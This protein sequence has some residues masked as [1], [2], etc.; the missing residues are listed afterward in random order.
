MGRILIVVGLIVAL[1]AAVFVWS[2]DE[3]ADT[4]DVA[5]QPATVGD[6]RGD[7]G[8]NTG[9]GTILPDN[10][11]PDS[12]D[13]FDPKP[14][15][16]A[17]SSTPVEASEEPAAPTRSISGTVVRVSDGSPLANLHVAIGWID[18]D[19]TESLSTDDAPI[20]VLTLDDPPGTFTLAAVP[21]DADGLTLYSSGPWPSRRATH[22]IEPG[23]GDLTDL[24]LRF[25]SGFSVAGLVTDEN[26]VPIP[27]ALVDA[28][29]LGEITAD[30]TGHFFLRDVAPNEDTESVEIGAR[31]PWFQHG[32]EAVVVPR[33]SSEI[34]SVHV[35]LVGSGALEGQ[36]TDHAGGA[37]A[38][39][40]VTLEY[41]MT[42]NHGST[43][44]GGLDATSDAEGRYRIDHVPPGRYI[45]QSAPP[46]PDTGIDGRAD[47]FIP[48]PT[49]G[50][51][52]VWVPDV[53]V[54]VGEATRLDIALPSGAT[55]SG[56]VTDQYG[57]P[58]V[59]AVV[60]LEKSV[61]WA[62]PD[63]SGSSTT[64]SPDLRIVSS[65]SGD[66]GGETVLTTKE[67]QTTS[68][69]NGDYI[70]GR[71]TPGE[72]L[73]TSS[74]PDGDRVTQRETLFVTR[75]RPH[76]RDIQ[77]MTGVTMR[78]RVVDRAGEPIEG[79]SVQV[80]PSDTAVLDGSNRVTTDHDGR[81]EMTGLAPTEMRLAIFKSGYQGVFE[82]VDPAAPEAEYMMLPAPSVNGRVLDALHEEPIINYTVIVAVGG[83]TW[84]NQSNFEDGIFKVDVNNDDLATVTIR[85]PG[86]T[87]ESLENIRP[88]ET[89]FRPLEFRL[90]RAD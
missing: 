16:P 43:A 61:R 33:D 11:S 90:H 47:A 3:A 46:E 29:R 32:T 21:H 23:P 54:V 20:A 74:D 30:S 51:V 38:G 40:T 70:F 72:K 89:A 66:D 36:V 62:A 37:V 64:T 8:R 63:L 69:A 44:G 77:L 15:L 75:G 35:R 48:A 6:R 84:S 78:S 58:V 19:P 5:E 79:A 65:G 83:S 67:E 4:A 49:R 31:A 12:R 57:T 9:A 1:A 59:G 25:D 50:L 42:T 22:P 34:P 85:V 39:A 76:T 68:D 87:S 27:D 28:M 14:L 17:T 7:A 10:M 55:V 81:F 73:I 86:F 26:D 82:S 52:S 80:R 53:G 13:A 45:L 60:L 88:S 18:S 41:V 71:V 2:S 56:R 24:V